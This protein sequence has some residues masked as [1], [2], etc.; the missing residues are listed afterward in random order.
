MR[1]LHIILH[2]PDARKVFG[3]KE[4]VIMRKQLL[5]VRLS[6]S[7]KNRLSRDIRKKIAFSRR[8]AKASNAKLIQGSELRRLIKHA[9]HHSLEDQLAS[10]I[11]KIILFGSA[12]QSE[13]SL[14]S[15]ID[16]TV[17]FDTITKKNATEFRI[18][19]L[20][21]LDET[22]DIQVYNQLPQPIKEEIDSKGRILWSRK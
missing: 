11:Q 9:V 14:R 16:I 19:V 5:G 6:Q 2:D 15:D 7:E 22:L 18:R 13:Q 10:K 20:S 12:A 3:K 8:L 1:L 17:Q 4:I 21:E